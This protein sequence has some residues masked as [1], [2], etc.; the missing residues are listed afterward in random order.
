MAREDATDVVV[1]EHVQHGGL[2][3]DVVEGVAQREVL[4]EHR[5]R[6]RPHPPQIV[7]QPL[8]PTRT[9]VPGFLEDLGGVEADEVDPARVEGV[10]GRT[11]VRVVLLLGGRV[12]AHVVVP[13]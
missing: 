1:G 9:V 8:Q 11:E 6:A 7:L 12:P 10:R 4:E 5:G 13:G 3:V 2:V